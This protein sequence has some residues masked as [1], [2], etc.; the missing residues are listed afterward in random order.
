MS[1]AQRIIEGLQEKLR[2]L[3][4]RPRGGSLPDARVRRIQEHAVWTPEELQ[5]L[6]MELK[7]KERELANKARLLSERD[8]QLGQ[9]REQLDLVKSLDQ[10]CSP[11][12]SIWHYTWTPTTRLRKSH[13]EPA[14]L[15]VTEEKGKRREAGEERHQSGKQDCCGAPNR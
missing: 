8:R 13:G 7:E 5:D 2:R 4:S 15:A 1:D 14:Q 12:R 3:E 9:L 11:D 6:R 10:R